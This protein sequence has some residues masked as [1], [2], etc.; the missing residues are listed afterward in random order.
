MLETFLDLIGGA[1]CFV[2]KI[3]FL[4]IG[5]VNIKQDVS[6]SF[7]WGLGASHNLAQICVQGLGKLP[8]RVDVFSGLWLALRTRGPL[9]L[10]M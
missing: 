6:G 5:W 2:Y 9:E 3:E 4:F 1:I 8:V 10:P 7:K